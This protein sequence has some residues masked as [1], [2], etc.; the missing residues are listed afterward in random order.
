MV[1]SRG[2]VEVGKVLEESGSVTTAIIVADG[3]VIATARGG[4][5]VRVKVGS[6]VSITTPSDPVPMKP[7][8]RVSRVTAPKKIKRK[9][10]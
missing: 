4:K 9:V 1:L 3:S 7:Q 2:R 8:A 6:R 5:G 10:I